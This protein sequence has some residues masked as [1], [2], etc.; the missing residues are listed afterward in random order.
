MSK[1]PLSRFQSWGKVGVVYIR[2]V[3][4]DTQQ[5]G[6]IMDRIRE[7]NRSNRLLMD[8]ESA[9]PEPQDAAP[10]TSASTGAYR[11]SFNFRD[12]LQRPSLGG[13][14]CPGE[15]LPH[16][17]RGAL[18]TYT[19]KGG[20]PKKKPTCFGM[21]CGICRR[22]GGAGTSSLT[23]PTI[24]RLS[25]VVAVDAEGWSCGGSLLPAVRLAARPRL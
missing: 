19:N 25:S 18:T 5:R 8:L 6:A 22:Q 12:F 4:Q 10:P 17:G 9:Y 2:R 1:R 20:S 3:A 21:I 13:H 11:P 23:F 14:F 15:G 16:A 7:A 24:S